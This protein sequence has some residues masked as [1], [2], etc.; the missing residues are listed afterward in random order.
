[1]AARAVHELGSRAGAGRR[2]ARRAATSTRPTGRATRTRS[3]T[4]VDELTMP[5]MA[6][7]AGVPI[8]L[9]PLQDGG[10]VDFRDPIGAA[11]TI[12]TLHSEVRTFGESFG[13][14]ECSFRL[15]LAPAVLERVRALAGASDERDRRRSARGRA[16]VG[17]TVSAHVIEARRRTTGSRSRAVTAADGGVGAGRRHRL[18]GGAGRRG[19]AAAGARPH[20]ARAARCRRSAACDPT[21]CS[22]S[23]RRATAQFEVD[24]EE[25][26]IR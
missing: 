6:L 14:S 12:Y 4:L 17:R 9:E 10:A 19:C 16:P 24:T 25:S 1:M 3:R 23:W 15:S 22:R 7:R 11:E 13:C 8:E 5:P 2:A 21:T 18:D 20:R 26:V